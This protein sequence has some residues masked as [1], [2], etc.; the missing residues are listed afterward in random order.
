MERCVSVRMVGT[1]QNIS[2]KSLQMDMSMTNAH[3]AVVWEVEGN[4]GVFTGMEELMS[5]TPAVGHN[6]ALGGSDPYDST[7]RS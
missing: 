5:W 3:G 7:H 1:S 2:R 6:A 4:L